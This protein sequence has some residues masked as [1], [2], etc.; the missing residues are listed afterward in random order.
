MTK[1]L[2]EMAGRSFVAMHN[3]C[4]FLTD[5]GKETLEHGVPI[6]IVQRAFRYCAVSEQLLPREAYKL[7]YTEVDKIRNNEFSRNVRYNHVMEESQLVSLQGMDLAKVKSKRDLSITDEALSFDEIVGYS[8]GY[9]Q[10]K[11]FL[12]GK[13]AP[14]RAIIAFG[15]TCLEYGLKEILN[16]IT[17]LKDSKIKEKLDELFKR[18]NVPYGEGQLSV[19][20]FGLPI[21]NIARANHEW[22]SKSLESGQQAILMCGTDTLPAKPVGLKGYGKSANLSGLTIRYNLLDKQLQNDAAKLRSYIERCDSYMAIPYDER[23]YPKLTQYI[24][25]SISKEEIAELKRLAEQYS[26]PRVS[27]T[28]PKQAVVTD[29]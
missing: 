22:L 9:L 29:Q 12:V 26:I 7:P 27:K 23:K 24:E 5:L 13:N 21:V 18:D 16:T 10:T 4:F 14:E 2:S 25:K 19:D 28:L 17:G 11:I 20:Q 6:R 8:S 1:H 3:N 15:K